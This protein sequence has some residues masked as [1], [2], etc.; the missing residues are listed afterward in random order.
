MV[1]SKGILQ[2][3]VVAGRQHEGLLERY[4]EGG[5]V[6]E[7]VDHQHTGREAEV[8]GQTYLKKF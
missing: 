2:D 3:V 6:V 7:K 5:E 8:Q 1:Q 4:E